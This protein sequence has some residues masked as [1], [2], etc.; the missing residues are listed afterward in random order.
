[1]EKYIKRDKVVGVLGGKGVI[2]KQVIQLLTADNIS[3]L[4]VTRRINADNG[5]EQ[6]VD[7]ADEASVVAFV[8]KCDVVVNCTGPSFLTSKKVLPIA[9]GQKKDFID[10]FGWIKDSQK[11]AHGVSRIVLNAGSVPGLLGVLIKE[12]ISKQT[13]EIEVFSGGY[14]KGSIASIGDILISS[15]NGYAHSNCYC[16]CGQLVRDN[17]M[18]E[19]D[20]GIAEEAYVQEVATEEIRRISEGFK[21]PVLRNYN[22][23][24]DYKLTEI[25]TAGCVQ[26]M[27]CKDEKAYMDLF[28]DVF[29]KI[30]VIA[31]GDKEP[32]YVIKIKAMEEAFSECM[33][34]HTNDSGKLTASMVAYCV[35]KLL[36]E[37]LEPGI[38]WP[39]E[40]ADSQKVI[41]YL[42]EL[43][44]EVERYGEL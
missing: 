10:A 25:I 27:Q 14:E 42:E 17:K 28:T 40:I 34:I 44:F 3:V 19:S 32:W 36:E 26:A 41:D 12:M 38:Y 39:Y 1:M 33:Q 16:A 23:W 35:K 22:I 5:S 18:V 31:D 11:V 43:S 21:V 30:S 13:K 8:R 24:S 7:L 37:N 15:I 29:T 6:Y 2:G 9:I 20:I 4:C